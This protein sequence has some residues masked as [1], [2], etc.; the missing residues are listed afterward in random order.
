MEQLFD[1]RTVRRQ[2]RHVCPLLSNFSYAPI[3][4]E[5]VPR[6]QDPQLNFPTQYPT[7]G[8]GAGVAAGFSWSNNFLVTLCLKCKKFK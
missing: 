3:W 4:F 7:K 8:G 6:A 2:S 1:F 5:L